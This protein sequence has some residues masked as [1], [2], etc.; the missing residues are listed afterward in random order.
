MDRAEIAQ[1]RLFAQ[2]EWMASHG[3]SLEAYI[4]RYGSVN[5]EVHYGNG[6]EAIYDADKAELDKA[7]REVA[8]S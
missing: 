7:R 1:A 6:G 8:G 2:E 4:A 5:D 3:G